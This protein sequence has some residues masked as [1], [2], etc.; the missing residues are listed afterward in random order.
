MEIPLASSWSQTLISPECPL[1]S[2]PAS[3]PG[4][5]PQ[6]SPET[7]YFSP[8]PTESEFF[9]LLKCFSLSLFLPLLQYGPHVARGGTCRHLCL[10]Q[11]LRHHFPPQQT[12]AHWP[13]CCGCHPV[14]CNKY[15]FLCQAF[16]HPSS[17]CKASLSPPFVSVKGTSFQK[18]F[19][20]YA[21]FF[22]PFF[23]SALRRL[24]LLSCF[25]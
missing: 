5:I 11:A 21:L 12:A 17:L 6:T 2:S 14:L 15:A 24:S 16:F 20:S 23:S 25:F 10:V 19:L 9:L 4:S 3:L 22:S 18:L 7:N 1:P 13:L 8:F